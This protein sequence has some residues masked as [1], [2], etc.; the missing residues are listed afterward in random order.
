MELSGNK[1][2]SRCT[3]MESKRA[4]Q[5]LEKDLGRTTI[6]RKKAGKTGLQS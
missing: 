2:S 6:L 4:E 3:S 1:V 5:R